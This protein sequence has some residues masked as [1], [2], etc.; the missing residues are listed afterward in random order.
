MQAGTYNRTLPLHKQ[1]G[2]V[3]G[4]GLAAVAGVTRAPT[5]S[6]ST[7]QEPLQAVRFMWGYS[8]CP[9]VFGRSAA[10][11]AAAPVAAAAV[12]SPAAAHASSSKIAAAALSAR[13]PAAALPTTSF[14][15]CGMLDPFCFT[16]NDCY[17]RLPNGT[18]G[19][20]C[21]MYGACFGGCCATSGRC[22]DRMGYEDPVTH[23][24]S[25]LLP[26][27]C[28]DWGLGASQGTAGGNSSSAVNAMAEILDC[29]LP[30]HRICDPRVPGSLCMGYTQ[31][32]SSAVCNGRMNGAMCVYMPDGS[33]LFDVCSCL[34]VYPMVDLGGAAGLL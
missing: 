9:A 12:H 10:T 4:S 32:K 13:E 15:S 5:G 25:I 23:Q 29:K 24:Q 18:Y 14:P 22:P 6:S 8:H 7:K 21:N 16:D 27:T 2:R 1:A 26:T 11:A 28:M 34:P 33:S 30:K 20:A 31:C 19:A 17:C 3:V